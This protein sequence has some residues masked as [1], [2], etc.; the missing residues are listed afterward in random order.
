MSLSFSF[1]ENSQPAAGHGQVITTPP[2]YPRPGSMSLSQPL[3]DLDTFIRNLPDAQQ[4]FVNEIIMYEDQWRI[5][6]RGDQSFKIHLRAPLVQL[7]VLDEN[8]KLEPLN[9]EHFIYAACQTQQ[10][11]DSGSAPRK[12]GPVNI[13]W[14]VEQARKGSEQYVN[15]LFFPDRICKPF[16]DIDMPRTDAMETSDGIFQFIGG[17]VGHCSSLLGYS[18]DLT[19]YCWMQCFHPNKVSFHV[20][21]NAGIHYES[22]RHI[23]AHLIA[24]GFDIKKFC[25]DMHVYNSRAQFRA[26]YSGKWDKNA[27]SPFLIMGKRHDQ[28][29]LADIRLALAQ[30]VYE[31]SHLIEVELEAVR[32]Q[33]Q[34]DEAGFREALAALKRLY[35]QDDLTISTK[36]INSFECDELECG[37][38]HRGAKIIVDSRVTRMTMRV[39]CKQF[40]KEVELGYTELTHRYQRQ[41]EF[42]R[43]F[44]VP[45]DLCR[46]DVPIYDSA[47]RPD[48]DFRGFGY[49]E[50]N[51]VDFCRHQGIEPPPE[52]IYFYVDRRRG[53]M[54]DTDFFNFIRDS[55]LVERFDPF[56]SAFFKCRELLLSYMSLFFAQVETADTWLARTKKGVISQKLVSIKQLM[57]DCCYEIAKKKGKGENAEVI[58]LEKPFWPVFEKHGNYQIGTYDR[59]PLL[60]LSEK[61]LSLPFPKRVDVNEA[62]KCWK[63][64]NEADKKCMRALWVHYLKMACEYERSVDPAV[65]LK[66]RD[67]LEKWTCLVMFDSY[68]ATKVCPVFSSSSG[69]QGKSSLLNFIASFLGPENSTMGRAATDLLKAQFTGGCNNFTVLDEIFLDMPTVE[70]LKEAVVSDIFREERKGENATQQR[71]RRNF[72]ATTNKEIFFAVNKHGKER[73]FCIYKFLG[74]SAMD[75][76]EDGNF[77]NYECYCSNTL[78]GGAPAPCAEHSFLDHSSFMGCF[79][80]LITRM[81]EGDGREF[82]Q[83]RSGRLFMPFIGMLYEVYLGKRAEWKKVSLETEI[84]NLAGTADA[85]EKV[86]TQAGK[87]IQE[88][89]SRGFSFSA[90]ENPEKVGVTRNVR[91]QDLPSFLVKR[92][93]KTHSWEEYVPRQTLYGLYVE[94]CEKNNLTKKNIHIFFSEFDNEYSEITGNKLEYKIDH[95]PQQVLKYCQG[96]GASRPEFQN[97]DTPEF[98]APSIYMGSSPEY[99]MKRSLR[100]AASAA[101][102]SVQQ[103]VAVASAAPPPPP[104]P[105][106]SRNYR[107]PSPPNPRRQLLI[108]ESTRAEAAE[109]AYRR[110]IAMEKE[111]QARDLENAH[112]IRERIEEDDA[113]DG[114]DPDIALLKRARMQQEPEEED[115]GA[116]TFLAEQ[117]DREADRREKRMRA[118]GV[119][120]GAEE[121]EGYDELE[122]IDREGWGEKRMR[123]SDDGED[124]I[125]LMDEDSE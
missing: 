4:R 113:R 54:I 19:D 42:L 104:P 102:A 65:A 91:S 71:N 29:T 125:D 26:P 12:Y 99:L 64:A 24:S 97:T 67:F 45:N 10:A 63:E 73:R 84:P 16:F 114:Y 110:E 49:L 31:P 25:V 66:A 81:E 18:S 119:D 105:G 15:E 100:R 30:C 89:V 8:R 7:N 118:A 39:Q 117:A 52:W 120:V 51:Y 37:C 87:L 38:G 112:R 122:D 2:S 44:M 40:C 41:L 61:S 27:Y 82:D 56:D 23:G 116:M 17:F 78:Q 28:I 13:H 90:A 111:Q 92:N 46:L 80:G 47:E 124:G 1:S 109:A 32:P 101:H 58:I 3:F 70:R 11:R 106:Q 50:L 53:K 94:W 123:Q 33:R 62:L 5:W 76:L 55:S 115:Q 96:Y 98:T 85:Q 108:S 95:S 48:P 75:E 79:H 59:G 88:W 68:R 9:C 6:R 72:A 34:P 20:V 14:I 21:V 43:D 60:K 93:A 86:Q 103:T 69:G 121:D 35:D 36:G 107:A 22:N 83:L 74:I 57:G 77:F